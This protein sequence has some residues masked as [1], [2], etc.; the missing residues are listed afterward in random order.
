MGKVDVELA[1]EICLG[2]SILMVVKEGQKRAAWL[3]EFLGE[4]ADILVGLR[5]L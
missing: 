4:R 3:V 5:K 1:V 2:E